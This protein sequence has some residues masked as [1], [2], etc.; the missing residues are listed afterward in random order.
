MDISIF[1]TKA[2]AQNMMNNWEKTYGASDHNPRIKYGDK[3]AFT[4]AR[5]RWSGG[6]STLIGLIGVL[7][8]TL[9][10]IYSIPWA[11][12]SLALGV[13]ILYFL[14]SIYFFVTALRYSKEFHKAVSSK[15]EDK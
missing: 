5:A 14:F 1:S 8:L 2:P 6:V 7:F 11:F 9:T 15:P 13:S 12:G 4:L 3:S 10:R